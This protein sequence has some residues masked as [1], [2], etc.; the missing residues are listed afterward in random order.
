MIESGLYD[1]VTKTLFTDLHRKLI[2][3][4]FGHVMSQYI[5]MNQQSNT[6][7]GGGAMSGVDGMMGNNAFGG[8]GALKASGSSFQ[9]GGKFKR[10]SILDVFDE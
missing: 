3:N 9:S 10:C 4:E 7:I 5:N 6:Q 2:K 8:G 1:G